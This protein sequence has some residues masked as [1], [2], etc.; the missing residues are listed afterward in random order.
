VELNVSFKAI[1]S[2]KEAKNLDTLMQHPFEKGKTNL[3]ILE[4]D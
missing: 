3:V 1:V 4:H 2:Q